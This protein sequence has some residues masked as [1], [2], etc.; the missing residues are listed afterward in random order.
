MKGC[1]LVFEGPE[2]SGKSL[3]IERLAERL[4]AAGVPRTVT[5]EPGGT[6]A[7]EAI[8]SV[9]LDRPELR[10]DGIA[11]LLLFSAARH[12]H[13]EEVIRPALTRGD[14]VLCDRFELSTRVYQGWARGVAAETIEQV[15][16][17]ATG[18]LLPELYLVLDVPVNVGL[19]RQG[20]DQDD[21]GQLGFFGPAPDR[22]ELEERSFRE[23]VREGY[24][25][26]AA[27][28]ERIAIL[29]G[30]GTPDQV[31]TRILVALQQRLPGRFQAVNFP[32]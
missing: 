15:T 12:A 10:L 32:R 25:E 1:F 30:S 21:P 7:A 2:G 23:R 6:A 20:Q 11:E 24:R 13:V 17:A 28:D 31:E 14:V 26:L 9:L 27:A 8:R 19:G 22:I 18:G 3:Q 29:D 5:R 4:S 16:H